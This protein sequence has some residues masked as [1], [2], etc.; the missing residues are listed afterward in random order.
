MGV[1]ISDHVGKYIVRL[2]A[3]S[4][5]VVLDVPV[6]VFTT[7]SATQLNG[8]TISVTPSVELVLVPGTIFTAKSVNPLF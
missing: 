7:T 2:L 3:D 5:P 6:T 8:T 1:V 4:T